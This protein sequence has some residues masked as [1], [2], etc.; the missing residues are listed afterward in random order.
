M[1]KI[2]LIV[3]AL[4]AISTV[5]GDVLYWMVSDAEVQKVGTT[6]DAFSGYSTFATLKATKD[7]LSEDLVLS[8]KSGSQ[9][10]NTYDGYGSYEY[11]LASP[12]EAPYSAYSFYIELYNG[13]RTNPETYADL[14]ANNYIVPANM[15]GA[16]PSVQGVAFGQG[17]G[18]NTYNVPEPTSG[19]LFLVGGMLLGLKRRRQQ[20]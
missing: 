9:V 19:L 20:V 4:S 5:R 17:A 10:F 11:T 8:T 14:V 3:V 6:A 18:H 12:L 15:T 13:S 7:G 16:T 1:K 2:L